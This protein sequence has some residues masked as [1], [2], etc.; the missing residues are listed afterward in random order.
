MRHYMSLNYM[1]YV[2]VSLHDSFMSF[3]EVFEILTNNVLNF[4]S[5]S[6]HVK[7]EQAILPFSVEKKL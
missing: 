4:Y 3:W 5:D 7:L 6:F 1:S 2:Y